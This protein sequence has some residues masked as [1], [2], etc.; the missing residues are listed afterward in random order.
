EDLLELVR[1]AH[2]PSRRI[3]LDALTGGETYFFRE[4]L[5]FSWLRTTLTH[6]TRRV[7]MWSAGCATGEEAYSMA[8]LAWVCWGSACYEPVEIWASDVNSLALSQARRAA[9]RPWSFRAM[10]KGVQSR[11]FREQGTLFELDPEIRDLVRFRR[12]NLAAE[13]PRES[14][15]FAGSID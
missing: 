5:H 12:H 6:A 2:E 15:A 9:F 1:S 3:L 13:T 14:T 11:W 8:L 4:A 7:R 10:P